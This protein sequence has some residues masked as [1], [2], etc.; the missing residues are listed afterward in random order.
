LSKVECVGLKTQNNS[1]K[2]QAILRPSRF[3]PIVIQHSAIDFSTARN[4]HKQSQRKSTRVAR[5][6]SHS[7]I[8]S[9]KEKY[10]LFY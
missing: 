4:T 1:R 10:A 5:T 7:G 3:S 8:A 2:R 9:G 6:H